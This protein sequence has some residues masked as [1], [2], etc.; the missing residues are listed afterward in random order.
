MAKRDVLEVTCDRCGRVEVQAST[1]APKTKDGE[2]EFTG[3]LHGDSRVFQDMCRRCRLGV[4]GYFYR[5]LN[6]E[7]ERAVDLTPMEDLTNGPVPSEAPKKKGL[8]GGK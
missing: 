3:S 4:T 2:P 8:F 5:I 6:K 7:P 1:D